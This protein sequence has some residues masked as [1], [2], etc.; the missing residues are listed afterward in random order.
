MTRYLDDDLL[1]VVKASVEAMPCTASR[2]QEP[3]RAW[4]T[5]SS[6]AGRVASREDVT[7]GQLS[8]ICCFAVKAGAA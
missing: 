8:L 4:T 7:L 5:S 1:R 3:L 6:T 2:E